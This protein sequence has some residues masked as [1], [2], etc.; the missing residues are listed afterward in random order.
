MNK[1]VFIQDRA[2]RKATGARNTATRPRKLYR[3]GGKPAN[4]LLG[5]T[6]RKTLLMKR[7]FAK[8][9]LIK[10]GTVNL[11]DPKAKSFSIVKIKT[12]KENTANKQYVRRN[13]ITKGTI[14]ETE[15]GDAKVTSRPGQT[16]TVNAILL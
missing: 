2:K 13:I 12:V 5:E 11:F 8:S 15:Q 16:G 3:K 1:M 10:S 7:N 6:K 14:V 9:H 4:T